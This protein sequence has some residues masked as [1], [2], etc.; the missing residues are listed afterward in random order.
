MQSDESSSDD[1]GEN[2]SKPRL[3]DDS[4]VDGSP[5]QTKAGESDS[6]GIEDVVR[7]TD[8]DDDRFINFDLIG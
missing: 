7:Q 2:P 1:G 8:S 6:S 4:N 3:S 5:E